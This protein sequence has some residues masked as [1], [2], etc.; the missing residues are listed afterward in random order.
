MFYD[1]VSLGNTYPTFRD[2]LLEKYL[3]VCNI[4]ILRFKKIR[5]QVYSNMY[6]DKQLSSYEASHITSKETECIILVEDIPLC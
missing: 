4:K 6:V 1:A 2:N 3:R 5:V